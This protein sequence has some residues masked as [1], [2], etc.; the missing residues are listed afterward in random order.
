MRVDECPPGNVT[1]IKS[2]DVFAAPPADEE[3][4]QRIAGDPWIIR[5]RLTYAAY[6][7]RC[8]RAG[9]ESELGEW[10]DHQ[11]LTDEELARLNDLIDARRE[12]H[13]VELGP[14]FIIREYGNK[15]RVGWFDGRGELVTMSFAEFANAHAEKMIEVGRNKDG[16]PIFKP[17]VSYW[18][19]HLDA[20]L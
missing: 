14:R 9:K 3:V 17:L 1:A 10:M 16:K 8:Q 5:K 19:R 4:D 7:T 18:L 2:A 20:A 11:R 6:A 12:A 13:S 15:A